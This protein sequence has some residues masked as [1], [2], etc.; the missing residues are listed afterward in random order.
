MPTSGGVTL[1]Y[2]VLMDGTFGRTADGTRL[3]LQHA[4]WADTATYQQLQGSDVLT[5]SQHL[6]SE[7]YCTTSAPLSIVYTK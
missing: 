5:V 7:S 4:T 1:I 2:T 3:V 6:V